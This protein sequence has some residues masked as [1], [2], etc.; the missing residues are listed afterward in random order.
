MLSW[1]S[2]RSR[3]TVTDQPLRYMESSSLIEATAELTP[4]TL[5]EF[6][7]SVGEPLLTFTLQAPEIKVPKGLL[8]CC[9]VVHQPHCDHYVAGSLLGC[10][11]TITF[12]D[13]SIQERVPEKKNFEQ[14]ILAEPDILASAVQVVALMANATAEAQGGTI[15]DLTFDVWLFSL[16]QQIH[17]RYLSEEIQRERD[18][19]IAS[20]NEYTAEQIQNLDIYVLDPDEQTPEKLARMLVREGF[21]PAVGY[22]DR[23]EL[24]PS[25]IGHDMEHR[26]L[27]QA[28]W[29]EA[30]V[31]PASVDALTAIPDD[32]EAQCDP[33]A[34][35]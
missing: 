19:R 11:Y 25:E 1:S 17:W 22:A 14:D 34:T 8:N 16:E 6:M 13:G 20:F 9:R 26:Y 2:Q 23:V 4:P 35:S 15:S 10:F 3:L 31:V 12:R 27:T 29:G 18:E 30:N 32:E 5:E 7:A 24:L 28:V 21:H 33:S